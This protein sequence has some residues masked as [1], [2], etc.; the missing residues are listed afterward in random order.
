V[1]ARLRLGGWEHYLDLFRSLR[2]FLEGDLD[3]AERFAQRAHDDWSAR[4]MARDGLH[5]VAMFLI[6]RRQGRLS[7]LVAAVRALAAVDPRSVWRPGRAAL[8]AELD[9][10]DEAR[11]DFDILAAAGFTDLPTDGS[12]ELCLG[13]L[14]E[15]CAKLGVAEH[16]PELLRQLTPCQGRLLVPVGTCACLGP[17][18]RLLGLLAATAGQAAEAA[19]WQRSA[20]ELSVRLNSPL[21]TPAH[22]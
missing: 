15:V 20:A 3:A 11:A 19:R 9:M 22:H 6:R 4:G 18:D 10:L 14:A 13:L 7:E 1:T 5:G 8:Y 16:A 17:T 12:R 2:A 21:W